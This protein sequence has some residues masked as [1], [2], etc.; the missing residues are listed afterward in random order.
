ML[1]ISEIKGKIELTTKKWTWKSG[2]YTLVSR[3]S[4]RHQILLVQTPTNVLHLYLNDHGT[5]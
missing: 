1:L 5:S 4:T 2:R 3:R